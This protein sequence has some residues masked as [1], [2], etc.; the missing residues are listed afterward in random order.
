MGFE[1]MPR[2]GE[3]RTRDVRAFLGAAFAEAEHVEVM[4]LGRPGE[5]PSA[6]RVGLAD[7]PGGGRGKHRGLVCSA[8]V[9]PK[10]VLL[11]DGKGGLACTS[12]LRRRTRRQTERTLATWHQGGELE[13]ALFRAVSGPRSTSADVLGRAR[14]LVQTLTRD[15]QAQVATLAPQVEA[16]LL[17]TSEADAT[18]R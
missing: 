1:V 13:D 9:V 8:C 17:M 15:S 16:V 5:P 11:T 4:V 18:R 12:C 14:R 3:V 2:A 6:A 7:L 10:I